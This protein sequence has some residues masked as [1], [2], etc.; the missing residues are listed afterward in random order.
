MKSHLSFVVAIAAV[1]FG[2]CHV[3]TRENILRP[4]QREHVTHTDAPVAGRPTIALTDAGLLRFIEPLTCPTEDV[5]A[6]VSGTEIEVKP[7]LA[8]FVVG[9]VA[10]S[11]GAI[12][13][14]R[15]LSDDDPAGSPFTYA[16]LGMLAAGLPFAVG[17]WLGTRTAL[18]PGEPRP[19]IRT[20][21]HAEACG[22]R[23]LAARAATLRVRGIEIR[24]TIDTDGVFSVS[25]YM[26]VDAWDSGG[27]PTWDVEADIDTDAGVRRVTA[28]L[29]GGQLAVHAKA[30]L[31]KATFSTATEPFRLV[32]GIVAGEPHVTAANTPDGPA[33][34]IVMPIKN[35]GPGPA[36][37]VR[38]HVSAPGQPSIDGRVLYVGALAKGDARTVELSIPVTMEALAALRGATVDLSV[39]L[40][41]AY[42]TAPTTP[43]RFRGSIVLESSR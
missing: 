37:A 17:P 10:T 41:D 27:V 4:G 26:I 28:Q 33:I 38:G 7:N 39:E 11:I 12:A 22:E 24:G 32:P 6:Q 35:D 3:T 5:I 40:K 14:I 15:G 29:D 36:W 42:G 2:G 8:T 1:A 18:V 25:P 13:S 16:G 19:P 21:G 30:F 34:R 9:V 31:A 23:P 20:P 43:I